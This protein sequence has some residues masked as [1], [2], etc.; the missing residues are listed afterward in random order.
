MH[1][2]ILLK[3]KKHGDI[4]LKIKLLA[5]LIIAIFAFSS[6]MC[7]ADDDVKSGSSACPNNNPALIGTWVE[8]VYGIV[9][10]FD[11]CV[12][13]QT[14]RGC[15]AQSDY[16]T[17]K[18]ADPSNT[19][20]NITRKHNT[21]DSNAVGTTASFAINISGSTMTEPSEAGDLIFL[22]K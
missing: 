5:A 17:Q 22:K 12:V 18:T 7:F 11:G 16:V 4:I 13:T 21:C 14:F 6:G 8:S 9:R 2:V 3:T 19:L 20:V 10:T 1:L 15:I